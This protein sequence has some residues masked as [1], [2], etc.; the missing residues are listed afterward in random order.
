MNRDDHK[1][2]WH[3]VFYGSPLSAAIALVILDRELEGRIMRELKK[4]MNDF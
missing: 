4:I 2:L 3:F 1:R